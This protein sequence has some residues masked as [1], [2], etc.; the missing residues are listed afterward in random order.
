M[1]AARALAELLR[2]MRGTDMH[3]IPESVIQAAIGGLRPIYQQNW[4]GRTS[5]LLRLHTSK[6]L[7]QDSLRLSRQDAS[8]A[9]AP[10]VLHQV[11]LVKPE[12]PLP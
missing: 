5:A 12:A 2:D 3:P 4:A 6:H 1:T 11:H 7:V 10:A 8:S 9:E